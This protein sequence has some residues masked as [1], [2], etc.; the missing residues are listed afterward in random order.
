MCRCDVLGVPK[1]QP[2]LYRVRGAVLPSRAQFSVG[3]RVSSSV[4]R[5]T[6]YALSNF[7]CGGW[8]NV[9]HQILR[10]NRCHY[11]LKSFRH[12]YQICCSLLLLL[13]CRLFF[14]PN[15]QNNKKLLPIIYF[16][17]II[18]SINFRSLPPIFLSLPIDFLFLI[19]TS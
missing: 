7:Y 4:L 14:L 1:L 15:F 11:S 13:F 19:F 18:R 16:L 10:C 12:L 6:P 2:G 3:L 8:E 5:T 17:L 9:P